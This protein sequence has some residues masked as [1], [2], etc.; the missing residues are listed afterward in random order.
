MPSETAGRPSLR[1]VEMNE[2]FLS[3]IALGTGVAFLV[4]NIG[5]YIWLP[6]PM[7]AMVTIGS[8][9]V[10]V[11]ELKRLWFGEKLPLVRVVRFP[12]QK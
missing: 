9:V 7:W 5:G 10:V 8:L 3:V 2:K 1:R 12:R 6:V 11:P 4:I